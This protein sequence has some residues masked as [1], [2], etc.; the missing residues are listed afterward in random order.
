MR[1]EGCVGRPLACIGDE[2]HLGEE[3]GWARLRYTTTNVR[4]F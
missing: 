3:R 1:V 4:A 2:A